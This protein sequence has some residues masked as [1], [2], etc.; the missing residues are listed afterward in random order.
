MA[1]ESLFLL[2]IH[3]KKLHHSITQ[4]S[5]VISFGIDQ[6]CVLKYISYINGVVCG[7]ECS[8]C[9]QK[10][11]GSNPRLEVYFHP[12]VFDTTCSKHQ[13]TL[14]SRLHIIYSPRGPE[15]GAICR[16]PCSNTP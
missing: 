7:L 12:Q 4:Q 10:V 8:N 6:K 1:L 2:E 14:F 15:S 11:V 16:F 3:Q 9:K 13:L 5:K